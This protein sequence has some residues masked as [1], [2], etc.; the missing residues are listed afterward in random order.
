MWFLLIWKPTSCMPLIHSTDNDL[1]GTEYHNEQSHSERRIRGI[2]NHQSSD[3]WIA[4]PTQRTWV[5]V[6]SGNWW[7]TGRP[8]VLQSMG[9]QRV[10][11]NW[12]TELN[13][14]SPVYSS[15]EISLGRCVQA[16]YT[17]AGEWSLIRLK[18]LFLTL[19]SGHDF[20]PHYRF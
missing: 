19:P 12:A 6:N 17:W 4:L 7:W 3:G 13:W 5:W 15:S 1:K 2:Q 8:G 14:K 20:I 9:S 18:M 10:G 11:Y 16:Q